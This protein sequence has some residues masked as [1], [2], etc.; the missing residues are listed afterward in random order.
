[1]KQYKVKAP[2]YQE[3]QGNEY[4]KG[5]QEDLQ[6]YRDM[7]N[8]L[9][10]QL[11]VT[12]PEVQKQYQQLA[13]DY[14]DAQWKDLNRKYIKEQNALNQRNYNRFGSLGSTGALYNQDALN[15]AYN[16]LATRVAASTASQYN[17]LMNDY[18]NQK[19]ATYGA[20]NNAYTGAG[21]TLLNIDKDN[22]KIRNTNIQAQYV[23]DAQN[24]SARANAWKNA[25][26]GMIEGAKTGGQFGGGWGALGGAIAGG[27]GGYFG[28]QPGSD[29]VNSSML[30]GNNLFE[31]N[32]DNK[33]NKD[34][35][36]VFNPEYWQPYN[37]SAVLDA[38][39][40]STQP[41]QVNIPDT[42]YQ[43]DNTT[44]QPLYNPNYI[45]SLFGGYSLFNNNDDWLNSSDYNFINNKGMILW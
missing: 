15:T 29:A 6:G 11:D 35:T 27:V 2:V 41:E 7:S 25:L 30:L 8:K 38:L 9:L 12:N 34:N 42:I 20:F 23:A 24:A 40:K 36:T 45:T 17:K 18:Y 28:G 32:K 3:F 44:T 14:T 26:S 5:L 37:T 31:K 22:W 43:T 4:T 39:Y 1:M 21:N 19:L 33:D 10:Y 16:D 13:N